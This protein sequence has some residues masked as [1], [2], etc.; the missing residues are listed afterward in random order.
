VLLLDSQIPQ[1]VIC[2]EKLIWTGVPM[3]ARWW[4]VYNEVIHECL[5]THV[6]TVVGL[7]GGDLSVST[8]C[9]WMSACKS[10]SAETCRLGKLRD[11]RG[12]ICNSS[13]RVCVQPWMVTVVFMATVGFE[14]YICIDTGVVHGETID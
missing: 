14:E 8:V 1:P 7:E 6:P 9:Q 5:P 13:C 12:A 10:H 2:N 4:H 11:A 3:L